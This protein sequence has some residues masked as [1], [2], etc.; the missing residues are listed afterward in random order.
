VVQAS[1]LLFIEAKIP[2]VFKNTRYFNVMK[3]MLPDANLEK[4]DFLA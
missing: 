3:S 4:L 2:V 1:S